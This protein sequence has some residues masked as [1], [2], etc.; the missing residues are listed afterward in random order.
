MAKMIVMVSDLDNTIHGEIN[1]LEGPD[2]ATRFVEG[3]IES[4]FEQERIRVFVG[5]EL[6]MEVHHRPVV[7]L[8][9]SQ[10][11]T[12]TIE[13]EGQ[14]SEEEIAEA[15]DEADDTARVTARASTLGMEEVTAEP[16]S[17]NGVRF[18]TLFRPA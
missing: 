13:E 18:S 14:T 7:S 4:G 10:P 8:S 16:Y 1:I 6:Q 3:L 5:D 9:Q 11:G 12:R 15:S 2:Q 17:K